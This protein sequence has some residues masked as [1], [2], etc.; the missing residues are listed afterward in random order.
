[1]KSKQVWT[2][3]WPVVR[4]GW[5]RG[6]GFPEKSTYAPGFGDGPRGGPAS[7]CRQRPGAKVNGRGSPPP[8]AA[9]YPRPVSSVGFESPP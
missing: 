6:P 1:M 2:K 9:S 7:S 8:R 4:T 5:G 3:V